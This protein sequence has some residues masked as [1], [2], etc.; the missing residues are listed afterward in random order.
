M[1]TDLKIDVADAASTRRW[2]IKYWPLIAG[3][4]ALCL[5]MI[6]QRYFLGNIGASHAAVIDDLNAHVKEWAHQGTALR[7]AQIDETQKA[8][9]QKLRDLQEEQ[10][11]MRHQVGRIK[12][13]T[14]STKAITTE[15]LRRLESIDQALRRQH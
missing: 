9:N 2:V 3:A 11:E 8:V 4:G 6:D 15:V 13:D 12:E 10:K 1:D 14:A 7:F 5:T